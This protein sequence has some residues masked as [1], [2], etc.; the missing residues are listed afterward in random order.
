M[1]SQGDAQGS[2]GRIAV[3]IV[4]YRPVLQD[5][6][7]S[8]QALLGAHATG[9][10]IEVTLWHNDPG[11]SETPG[12]DALTEE[13]RAHGLPIRLHT[14]NR[15]LGFGQAVNAAL[16]FIDAPWLL[17]LNQDAIPEPGAIESMARVAAKD[18][19]DVAA[20]ELRQIPY[21]HPKDYDPVTGETGWCSGAAVLLRTAALKQVGGFEPRF[22]MY[23][24]DVDLAWRLRCAGWRL[25]YLPRF[26]VV[27]RTYRYPGEVKPLAALGG[28]YANLCIRARFAGRRHV[29][30][31]L[32]DLY[33]RWRRPASFPG[34]K[35]G[36]VRAWIKFT[37]NYPY[38][39][40]TRCAA[41]GFAPCLNG[42][43]YEMRREGSFHPFQSHAE[44]TQPRPP[45]AVLVRAGGDPKDLE[46]WLTCIANQT[47][48]P[49]E[50]LICGGHS[51]ERRAICE[52]W[53]GRLTLRALPTIQAPLEAVAA[54]HA[55]ADWWLLFDD[56]RVLPYAD[57]AEV[58]LQ[59]ALQSQAQGAVGLHW[60]I[61]ASAGRSHEAHRLH[62]ARTTTGGPPM[63]RP[64][65]LVHRS[66]ARPS[67]EDRHAIE[68]EK[69]T[70]LRY[71]SPSG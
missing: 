55:E 50:V 2:A 14:A 45:I 70:T 67:G 71:A 37:A 62:A 43:D 25:R 7:S 23:C 13:L 17:L 10:L 57:H 30:D 63:T 19:P 68:V 1:K 4:I 64:S 51:V 42:H 32:R 58:L 6:R 52:A 47:H 46:D 27:H 44:Q 61:H 40:R 48:R 56:E 11:P 3:V 59:A 34:E 53:Q 29:L 15:N 5:L 35:L 18:A 8:L 24:E 36:L 21:E 60:T 31:G 26:A 16:P 41:P 12:L 54:V 28:A 20:W 38:F 22:F 66:A 49:L 69:L 33:R 9:I 39:R 65:R